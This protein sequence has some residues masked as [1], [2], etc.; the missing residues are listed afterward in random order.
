MRPSVMA[1][2]VVTASIFL[3]SFVASNSNLTGFLINIPDSA[4]N[5]TIEQTDNA[6]AE[7]EPIGLE[8]SAER[9]GTTA[10]IEWTTGVETISTLEAGNL[11]IAFLS[12]TEFRREITE[13][14]PDKEYN[15]SVKACTSER[16]EEKG[17]VLEAQQPSESIQIAGA[18]INGVLETRG[19][20]ASSPITGAAV[21]DNSENEFFE[22][23]QSA[24]SFTLY[25]LLA[26][27]A[28]GVSGIV[29]YEK[30]MNRE[31]LG[32]M[33]SDAGKMIKKNN[34][35]EARQV[36]I[37]ARQAFSELEEE[38][39]LKHYHDLTEIYYSLKRYE[40]VKE[41]QSLAEKYAK[42]SIS[43]EEFKKLSDMVVR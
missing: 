18:I 2:I 43:E 42:G 23:F 9:N 3:V 35:D 13:L 33:I 22:T 25:G 24:V 5:S 26:A 6:T 40:E 15:Y 34:H 31:S 11:Y 14:E 1:A 12:S 17:D 32:R 8:V 27:I 7:P 41:A 16:C 36:Y 28:L 38:A 29:A 20:G 19:S 4:D 39:K 21:S 30:I 10:V 37:K